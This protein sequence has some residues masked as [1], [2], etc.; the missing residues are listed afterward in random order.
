MLLAILLSPLI[1]RLFEP[2]EVTLEQLTDPDPIQRQ[3]HFERASLELQRTLDN[4]ERQFSFANLARLA[5]APGAP[6][7]EF[8]DYVRDLIY[9]PVSAFDLGAVIDLSG[10]PELTDPTAQA[11][12]LPA[13]G[14]A[15]R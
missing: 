12:Y 6:L 13:I 5:V 1:C 15:L 11:A 9:V 14:A 3:P 8:I 10:V 4:V 7:R 2:D